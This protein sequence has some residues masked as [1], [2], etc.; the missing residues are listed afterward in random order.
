[1]EQLQQEKVSS[2]TKNSAKNLRAVG[3]VILTLGLIS[4]VI[5]FFLTLTVELEEYRY[6]EDTY[7]E[8]TYTW[9]EFNPMS[10]VYSFSAIIS[11]VIIW[12]FAKAVADIVD[13][14]SK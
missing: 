8:Y 6:S 1:M 3:N 14:T 12:A 5:L 2:K 13:N 7:E 11:S 4:G 9:R 10:L